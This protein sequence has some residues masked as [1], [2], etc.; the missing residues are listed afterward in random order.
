M[1][2]LQIYE[3][4]TSIAVELACGMYE[5][6]AHLTESP[7]FA[8]LI[9]V[10]TDN[11]RF[12]TQL[13]AGLD[14]LIRN[15]LE[16]C[17]E[18]NGGS[19]HESD[20]NYLDIGFE[21]IE[22]SM[23]HAAAEDLF[24]PYRKRFQQCEVFE[25]KEG[26]KCIKFNSIS[27]EISLYEKIN[28]ILL[29]EQNNNNGFRVGLAFHS[30]DRISGNLGNVEKASLKSVLAT[31][32]LF[33][34]PD[35]FVI[36]KYT[37]SQITEVWYKVIREAIIF[38]D[39]NRI[40]LSEMSADNISLLS[41]CRLNWE[42]WNF[43]V[44]DKETTKAI[45]DELTFKIAKGKYTSLSNQPLLELP[46]GDKMI[47]PKFILNY[48]HERNIL[49]TLYRKYPNSSDEVKEGLFINDLSEVIKGYTS[50]EEASDINLPDT[51]VDYLL[52]DHRTSTLVAFELKWL[53]EPSTPVEIDNKDKEIEKAIQTQ[54]VNYENGIKADISGFMV[55]AFKRDLKVKKLFLFVLTRGTIGSGKV[56]RSEN[57]KVINFRMLKKALHDYK[58][59]LQNA[60][61]ALKNEEYYPK[62]GIHF[63][64]DFPL[65]Y[66]V[67]EVN[68]ICEGYN[69]LKDIS[70][71]TPMDKEGVSK[72]TGINL[73]KLLNM[74]TKPRLISVSGNQ[75][76]YSL[77]VETK[78]EANKNG[79]REQR[80]NLAKSEKVRSKRKRKIRKK[81]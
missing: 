20:Y 15:I 51:N 27:E 74:E 71:L 80:R 58:A 1:E 59:D 50:L 66:K 54:L 49:T 76:G 14:I 41:L 18:D 62:E 23:K 17:S 46:D 42:K 29:R 78:L 52:Y 40:K 35:E 65:S 67:G 2:G 25:N 10:A 3:L 34:M 48:A 12:I 69:I 16:K 4:K 81:K 38:S 79:N 32:L 26:D 11:K 5:T 37:M 53:T 24:K 9:P 63:S 68:V 60:A 13:H 45:L 73:D 72:V 61:E 28:E 22:K 44:V 57:Y 70:Y 75:I 64:S 55:K 21:A 36:G 8:S 7:K 43:Q 31:K 6:Y 19:S 30:I 47:S 56:K 33:E 77:A 39:E